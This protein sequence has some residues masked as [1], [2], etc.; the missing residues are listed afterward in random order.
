MFLCQ[1][2]N[3]YLTGQTHRVLVNVLT[4]RI[5]DLAR[6]MGFSETQIEKRTFKADTTDGRIT[7]IVIE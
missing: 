3:E 6:K 4:K 1:R 7:A 5:D 2:E